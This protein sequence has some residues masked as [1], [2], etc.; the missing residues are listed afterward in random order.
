MSFS[1]CFKYIFAL[2]CFLSLLSSL[3]PVHVS[4]NKTG[5]IT[6]LVLN[7]C[8]IFDLTKCVLTS[9]VIIDMQIAIM[10]TRAG[11]S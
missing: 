2:S 6:A 11:I 1:G 7:R 5:F 8:G 4:L 9:Q 3:C 10:L